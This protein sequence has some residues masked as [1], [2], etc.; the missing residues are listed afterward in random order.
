MQRNT[1]KRWFD[2]F[3]GSVIYWMKVKMIKISLI[4]RWLIHLLANYSSSWSSFLGESFSFFWRVII[5]WLWFFR[6]FSQRAVVVLMSWKTCVVFDFFVAPFTKKFEDEVFF[7]LSFLV[8]IVIK[9]FKTF[10]DLKTFFYFIGEKNV[11][12]LRSARKLHRRSGSC[13]YLEPWLINS[14]SWSQREY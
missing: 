1:L 9:R 2:K 3:I 8:R 13:C 14:F 10:L 12:I 6:F 11:L 5:V 7:K 4:I